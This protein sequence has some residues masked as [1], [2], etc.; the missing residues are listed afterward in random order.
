[1][2]ESSITDR[3][4]ALFEAGI[5]LGALYH[6]FTGSPVNL[7]TA[8][9]LEKAI[10]E[11]ISVQPFVQSIT[12]SIDR[13]MIRSGLNKEFGYCEL[14]GRMLDVK[15]R[16]VYNDCNVLVALKY[17]TEMEYP[18]MKIEDVE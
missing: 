6:Q 16:V 8:D 18:L 12:V 4:N 11:S 13:D 5:K 3:D 17:D 7:N 9:S 14:E 15:L 2:T 10:S 1:M